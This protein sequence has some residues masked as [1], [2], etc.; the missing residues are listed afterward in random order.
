MLSVAAPPQPAYRA[1]HERNMHEIAQLRGVPEELLLA[2][3]AV[4]AVLP[5]RTNAH[6]VDNLIDWSDV[7]H[8]PVYRLT[9]PAPGM[10]DRDD[11]ARMVE[12][13]REN[14][15]APVVAAEAHE[16]RRRLNPH[17]GKQLA[18]NVPKADGWSLRGLQHKYHQTVLFFPSPRQ[19]CHAYCTYCFRWA[20][21]V[22]EPDLKMACND[23]DVLRAYLQEHRE[24]TDVLITGGDPMVMRADVLARFIDPLLDPGFDSLRTIRIGTKSVAYWPYRFVSDPDADEIA[25]LFERVVRSG[26][27]LAVMAHYSHPRELSPQV[28]RE[29]VRRIRATGACVY[30]QAPLIRGI[31][32]RSETWAEL[33]RTAL[34]LG[35]V[36]YY[37]FVERDTGPR[38]YF[39]VPLVRAW[40][41]FRDAY[42]R[43]SGLGRTVR[44]P[45]MSCTPGKVAID[46]VTEVAGRELLGLHYIQ[47]RDPDLVDRPFFAELDVDATWFDQLVPAFEEQRMFFGTE[48]RI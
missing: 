46:G 32:D 3:R 21:F 36:P 10:L 8:D 11:L 6:V 47:A 33:W 9:F 25:R 13:L 40:R 23:S 24:V 27:Q 12:L 45:V 42:A 20:Q 34:D 7:E 15:P 31:N 29:A 4:A 16:I 43:I 22:G 5:F 48:R 19:T 30:V 37:M 1:F 2:M 18:L 28:A 14:A 39:E 35:M 17:P 26:R 38:N 41:I 44:G